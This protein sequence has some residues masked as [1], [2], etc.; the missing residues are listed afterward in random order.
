MRSPAFE[1]TAT[2]RRSATSMLPLR[3]EMD[4]LPMR[5]PTAIVY[6]EGNFSVSAAFFPWCSDLAAGLPWFSTAPMA[7]RVVGAM[8]RVGSAGR[9]EVLAEPAGRRVRPLEAKLRVVAESCA[10]GAS[11][12]EVARRHGLLANR[13]ARW[14]QQYRQGE[15]VPRGGPPLPPV[16]PA[17]TGS[18]VVVGPRACGQGRLRSAAL[19][20]ADTGGGGRPRRPGHGRAGRCRCG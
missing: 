16:A 6:C 3:A 13:V 19:R 15:P 17:G 5:T 20:A 7:R 8:D 4:G 18:A 9:M 10:E 2:P 1:P 12:G 11:V 14:R